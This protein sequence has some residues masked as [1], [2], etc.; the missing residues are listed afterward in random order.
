MDL[1]YLIPLALCGLIVMAVMPAYAQDWTLNAL[2]TRANTGSMPTITG[3][4][5]VQRQLYHAGDTI[6]WDNKWYNA[7]SGHPWRSIAVTS[8]SFTGFTST[9]ANDLG[10]LY[11]GEIQTFRNNKVP[12]NSNPNPYNDYFARSHNYGYT[13]NP[14]INCDIVGLQTQVN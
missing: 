12:V 4:S 9:T 7:D 6:T 13:D 3:D 1:K 2:E 8:S 5:T 14:F 10:E 11:Y